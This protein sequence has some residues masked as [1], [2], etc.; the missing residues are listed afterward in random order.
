MYSMFYNVMWIKYPHM[1]GPQTKRHPEKG[2]NQTLAK[3]GQLQPA[4]QL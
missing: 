1:P 3:Q 2:G 4:G